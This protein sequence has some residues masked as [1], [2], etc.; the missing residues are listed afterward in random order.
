ME[1]LITL[2]RDAEGHYKP[3][4]FALPDEPVAFFAGLYHPQ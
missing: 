3:I 1:Y 2:G 4:W